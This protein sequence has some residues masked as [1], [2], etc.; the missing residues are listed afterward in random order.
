MLDDTY[1]IQNNLRT[2]LSIIR[3]DQFASSYSLLIKSDDTEYY[4]NRITMPERCLR[5]M[6]TIHEVIQYENNI[7]NVVIPKNDGYILDYRADYMEKRTMDRKRY[8]LKLLY[9]MVEEDPT[10]PRHYYYLAQTYILLEDYENAAFWFHK[11]ATTKLKGHDQE[12][13]DSW[14]E[15]GRT[16]NFKLNKPWEE[17]KKCYEEAYRFEPTRPESLYFIGI[18]Y[19]LENDELSAY[20]YFKKAFNIGYPIHCQFS[21]KPT[22]SFHFLPKFFT[23]L[24]YKY[25]DWQLGL[26]SAE[27]YL[28]HNK[29]DADRY[30]IVSC[31][32][33]IHQLLCTLPQVTPFLKKPIKPIIVFVADGGWGPWTGSD[34]LTKGVGG[35]ETYIIEIARWVQASG[36]YDCFVFCKCSNPEVFEGVRYLD[37]KD[38]PEFIANNQVHTSIVSR[39]SEYVPLTLEGNVLNVHLVLHDLGPTCNVIPFN[40]KFRK[41]ICLTDWHKQLFSSE[42]PQLQDRADYFYYGID[43]N[44][45]K[46]AEKVKNSFIYSS[47]P[48]RGLLPLLQMWPKIKQAIPDAT[49]NVYSDINGKWVNEVAKDQMDIIRQLLA[50]GMDGVTVHGWVSKKD[51]AAAWGRAEFWLYPCI[52]KETFCLTALEA[53]ATKTLAIGPPL[54]ALG[55]TIGDRGLLIPGNPLEQEWQDTALNE[56]LAVLND[57]GKRNSLIESNYKWAQATTWQKRGE[58]FMNRYLQIATELDSG[59]MYNWV[60]D[61]PINERKLFEEALKIANPKLVLEIGT[62]TGTSLIEMLKL[63]PEAHGVAIDTWKNYDE[64]GQLI[65]KEMEENNIE[66]IFYDNVKNA[67]ISDRVE[68]YNSDSVQQLAKFI[69]QNREFDFIY[70]D[71][72]HKCLDCYGDMILAWQLLRRGGVMAVDDIKYNEDRVQNGE[73]LEWP[74]RAKEHFEEKF[75][76]EYEVISDEYRWF[77]KKL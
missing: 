28:M 74:K 24:C 29:P 69:K 37:L 3:G 13:Y 68:A 67:G 27:L 31:W 20:H 60:H 12:V 47:F 22:L 8:D 62:Y 4:S 72:G 18:H 16:Y 11:R 5:Y 58:E 9:E 39:Y 10:N 41:V 46:P 75:K 48:N 45:F 17:C 43:A 23:E 50:K 30:Y 36:R 55:E 1:V 63:Y 59:N 66:R 35:S 21:L 19:Y 70:V 65:L 71:A 14:F 76:G 34:I 73:V 42:F 40:D 26:K 25:K 57:T 61:I 53:A 38:Y 2:F 15:L 33:R 49:L 56:L 7:N 64:T 44:L 54:A 52:F 32:Y 51:L 77:I 6:Y